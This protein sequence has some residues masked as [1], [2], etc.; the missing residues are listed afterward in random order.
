LQQ[1]KQG[2][3]SVNEY[4]MEMEMVLQQARVSEP[5]EKT[6][7]H[8]LH[9]LKHNI[10]SIVRHHQYRDMN[11]LLH[12]AHEAEAQFAEEAQFKARTT[13]GSRFTS[14]MT[15]APTPSSRSDFHAPSSSRPDS[16]AKKSTPA[17][18]G[19]GS[20]M[21]IARNHDMQCHTCGGKGHFKWDCPNRKV[22]LVN[23]DTNEYETGDDAN[24]DGSDDDDFGHDG[25]DAFPS[26]ANSIVCSQHVLNVSA[27]S[28]SQQCNLFQTKALVGMDKDCK[29]QWW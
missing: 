26:T 22:V 13:S 6:L 21:S 1:L 15:A 24:L 18:S 8:F 28:E 29:H 9:G 2:L 25:V 10:K 4:Y 17:A 5:L 14:R 12:H 20:N 11:D 16:K 19:M 27:T 23:E 3:M 7:Q